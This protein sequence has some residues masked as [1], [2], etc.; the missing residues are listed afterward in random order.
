LDHVKQT[1]HFGGTG[2]DGKI[3]TVDVYAIECGVR[4]QLQ[5]AYCRVMVS[6]LEHGSEAYGFISNCSKA[7]YCCA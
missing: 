5:L 2:I 7:L 3:I 4:A 6:F 1:Y